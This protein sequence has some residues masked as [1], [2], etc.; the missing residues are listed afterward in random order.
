MTAQAV[1]GA[2]SHPTEDPMFPSPYENSPAGPPTQEEL[3]QASHHNFT[4]NRL[5]H[6]Q[7]GQSFYEPNEMFQGEVNHS[8][9]F[10]MEGIHGIH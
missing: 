10:P 2:E 5:Y 8:E 3:P 6:D 9:C 7:R 4:H 1:S